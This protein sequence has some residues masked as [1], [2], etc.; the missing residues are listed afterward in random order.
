MWQWSYTQPCYVSELKETKTA[1]F[2]IVNR[3]SKLEI[4]SFTAYAI[5]ALGMKCIWRRSIEAVQRS[6]KMKLKVEET[7]FARNVKKDLFIIVI[8]AVNSIGLYI[9]LKNHTISI[10]CWKPNRYKTCSYLMF[11]YVFLFHIFGSI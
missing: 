4:I 7:F 11:F 3:V 8:F 6:S 9:R 10:R 2:D 1:K 5:T